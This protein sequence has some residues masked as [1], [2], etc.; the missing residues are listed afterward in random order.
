[1]RLK[2]DVAW[3][4]EEQADSRNMCLIWKQVLLMLYYIDQNGYILSKNIRNNFQN[5]LSKKLL[6]QSGNHTSIFLKFY[7]L[8]NKLWLL[9]TIRQVLV[10]STDQKLNLQLIKLQLL[11]CISFDNCYIFHNFFPWNAMSLYL[12]KVWEDRKTERI[13]TASTFKLKCKRCAKIGQ[14]FVQDA[15]SAAIWDC[16]R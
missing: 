3:L 12:Y 11:K 4:W 2:H 6:V 9:K 16:F 13:K 5:L 14:E 1:M 7:L 10:Y 15:Q 8:P